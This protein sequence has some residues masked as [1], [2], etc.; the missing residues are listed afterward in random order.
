ML[1][2]SIPQDGGTT[3]KDQELAALN[4]AIEEHFR[5]N[6]ALPPKRRFGLN[7]FKRGWSD[8]RDGNP[9]PYH[10]HRTFSGSVTFS[11]AFRKEWQRGAD[12]YRSYRGGGS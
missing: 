12:A 8:A 7:A 1:D 5:S 4:T 10:D 6:P 3:A 2:F 9:C 11:R